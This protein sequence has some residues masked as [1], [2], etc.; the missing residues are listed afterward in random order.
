MAGVASDSTCEVVRV[1]DIL[2]DRGWC[3]WVGYGT[4]CEAGD[5]VVRRER[6]EDHVQLVA[7][8][9]MEKGRRRGPER[10]GDRATG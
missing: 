9:Y 2:C 3:W 7:L 10:L 6:R 8:I 4:S 1:K 5:G